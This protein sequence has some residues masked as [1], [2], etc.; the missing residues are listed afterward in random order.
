MGV[1]LRLRH[2]ELAEAVLGDHLRHHLVDRLL[3]ERDREVEVVAVL[4]HRR[5]VDAELTELLGDLPRP[6]GAEVEEDRGVLRGVE[7]RPAVEHDRQD[8]LVGEAALVALLDRMQRIRR[9][10]RPSRRRSR[11]ARAACA[12][13]ACRGPSRSSGRR[14]SRCRSAGSSA[15]SCQRGV[16]RD[17]AAVGERVDPRPVRHPFARCELEQ[18]THVVDVRVDAAVRDEPEQVHV[19]P[20]LLRAPERRRRA[21]RS[22][23]RCRR[24]LRGSRAGSPGRGCGPSRSSDARPPSCPSAPAGGRRPRPTRRAS[25]AGTPPRAGRRPACRQA[26]PRSPARRGD[27]PAVEDDERYERNRAAARISPAKDSTSSDAPPTSAPS[28]SGCASSSSALS[29]LTEPP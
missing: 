11:R 28:T 25:C 3:G 4:R 13:I 29:G 20:A 24:Q 2:V 27:P 22:R 7:P 15:R 26:R 6:V 16:R 1:L 10:A 9:R 5:Q 21:P 8:E 14:P 12:P 18:R 23:R 17:V 19:S